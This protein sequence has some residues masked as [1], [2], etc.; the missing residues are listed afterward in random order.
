MIFRYRV[1]QVK[2]AALNRWSL[3]YFS[4]KERHKCVV[5]IADSCCCLQLLT[6]YS[7]CDWH[8]SHVHLDSLQSLMLFLSSVTSLSLFFGSFGVH[9]ARMLLPAYLKWKCVCKGDFSGWYVCPLEQCGLGH[10]CFILF[11]KL[12]KKT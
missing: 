2:V 9:S 4:G 12:M 11:V 3:F 6:C 5:V 1:S 8:H 10:N 7:C